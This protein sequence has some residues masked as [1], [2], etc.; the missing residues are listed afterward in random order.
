MIALRRVRADRLP[1]SRR[2]PSGSAASSVSTGSGT[3]MT[4][5]E[6]TTT[7]PGSHAEQLGDGRCASRSASAIA[8]RAGARVGVAGVDDDGAGDA[9]GDVPPRDDDRGGGDLVGGEHGSRRNGACSASDERD[10][11][12]AARLEPRGDTALAT[13]PVRCGHAAVDWF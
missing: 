3:P 10:V 5:V 12:R 1:T 9:A 2:P 8:L 11:E 4:P 7:S 6:E 13:K